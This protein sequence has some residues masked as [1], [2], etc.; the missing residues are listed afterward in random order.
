MKEKDMNS[1]SEWANCKSNERKRKTAAAPQ[2][3]V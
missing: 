1:T 3:E 2:T